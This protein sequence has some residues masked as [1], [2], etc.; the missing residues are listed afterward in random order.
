MQKRNIVFNLAIV[1]MF[2]AA[3][4]HSQNSFQLPNGLTIS[5]QLEYGYDID[6][7]LEILENWLNADYRS[8]IFSTGIRFDI[9]QPNDPNPAISRG[10]DRFADISYKYLSAKIG[11]ARSNI[12]LTVGNFYNLF[13]RGMILKSYENRSIRIDNNLL[14]V[15]VN[16]RY[17]NF[18]LTALSGSIEN[19]QAERKDILHA[20][21][22][23]YKAIKK[24]KIGG[25]FASNQPN[26][27]GARTRLASVRV[28]PSFWN[29]DA[30]GEFGIKQNDDIKE[31]IFNGSENLAG[32]AY[33]G[34]LNF[35]YG[36][37]SLSGEYKV[38]D[39]FS[40]TSEDGSILYNTPP[41]VRNEY[42]YILLNR[43]PSQL[44]ADNE[45]GFQVEANYSLSQK[46][47]F[48]VN[49]GETKTLGSN[50]LYQRIRK[51]NTSSNSFL[52]VRTQ[53][54]ELFAHA[55]HEWFYGLTTVVGFG[56]N[57]ELA[58]NTKSITPILENKIYIDDINSF[59]VILEFQQT[60]NKN[61]SEQYYNNVVLIEYLRSPKLSI[62]LV[63]EMETREPTEDRVVRKVFGFVQVGYKLGE[64][65][66]LS[67]LAGSRQAGNICIG[68]VCRFEPEFSGVELKM[69]T[70]L[71]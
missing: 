17:S 9:F 33:Y 44:N 45:K 66:D 4:V 20:F 53:L 28:I 14:G 11:S 64:H 26:S 21:D 42:S 67:I 51:I 24:L 6:E 62:S 68:G 55:E 65:T 50:S 12:K 48:G 39:N 63:A 61:N 60:T 47:T 31:N 10:K 29:F 16:A 1:F 59:K 46:T 18:K 23:E 2:I 25:S 49:Y 36:S 27:G 70:R 57:E 41:A 5:N 19:S 37:F 34:N 7:K 13:G 43:H 35:Y 38:Y 40:F 32:K 56:Y 8:G 54:I 15:M 52:P 71:F 58:E 69:Q 22:L 3:D 30:Y